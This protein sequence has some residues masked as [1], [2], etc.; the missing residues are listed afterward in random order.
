MAPLFSRIRSDSMGS[1]HRAEHLGELPHP[2][3]LGTLQEAVLQ[4]GVGTGRECTATR[5]PLGV[6]WQEA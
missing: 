6:T 1:G 5:S 2:Q 3:P 4:G